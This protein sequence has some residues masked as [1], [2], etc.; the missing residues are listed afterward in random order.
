MIFFGRFRFSPL[1]RQARDEARKRCAQIDCETLA[2]ER[3]KVRQAVL[4]MQPEPMNAKRHSV[5]KVESFIRFVMKSDEVWVDA[6][7]LK[8][9]WPN[10]NEASEV[11]NFR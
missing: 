6:Q 2:L 8:P 7:H 3:L 4:Q 11:M 5:D 1:R 10:D 9:V